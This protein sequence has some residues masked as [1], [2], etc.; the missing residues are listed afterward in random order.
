M[1]SIEEK[2]LQEVNISLK[3]T[4][5]VIV[6]GEEIDKVKFEDSMNNKKIWLAKMRFEKMNFRLLFSFLYD[7]INDFFPFWHPLTFFNAIL[8]SLLHKY[9]SFIIR[10]SYSI[11]IYFFKYLSF[12]LIIQP[13]GVNS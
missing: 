12:I 6:L 7:C 11:C 9:Y 8:A 3:Y 10:I 5:Y 2:L 4:D 1:D 13:S